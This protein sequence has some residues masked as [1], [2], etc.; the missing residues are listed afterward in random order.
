MPVKTTLEMRRVSYC[1][2]MLNINPLYKSSGELGS[3]KLSYVYAMMCKSGTI[4][5]N[6]GTIN[7]VIKA[8]HCSRS[9]TKIAI[10]SKLSE[11]TPLIR[12]NLYVSR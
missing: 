4:V 5:R 3:E 11:T 1:V 6:L 7:R 9:D 8:P 12:N 10:I 2:T